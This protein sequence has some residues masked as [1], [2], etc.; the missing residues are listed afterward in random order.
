MVSQGGA[1]AGHT[2]NE[3][4]DDTVPFPRSGHRVVVDDGNL[5]VLGGYNPDVV[6]A[7][8]DDLDELNN[9][10]FVQLV[11]YPYLYIVGGTTGYIYNSDVHRLDLRTCQWECLFD[12][13]DTED[14]LE[15]P[16]GRFQ[17]STC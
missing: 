16:L 17:P 13:Q 3:R 5:Y 10:I 4:G 2:V 7:D 1:K 12:S 11:E 8:V 6:D 9:R 14:P 15:F